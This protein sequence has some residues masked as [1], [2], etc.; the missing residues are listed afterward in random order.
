M[1][2]PEGPTNKM[3]SRVEFIE[4]LR[5]RE[6]S[7]LQSPFG[8]LAIPLDEFQFQQLEQETEVVDI[9][10]RTLFRHF[11]AFG[12]DGRQP[13]RFEMVLEKYGTLGVGLHEATPVSTVATDEGA[14]GESKAP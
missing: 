13:Q 8:R 6:S 2:V 14:G 3:F 11:L 5:S 1:P 12:E 9:V 7:R 4:R 10:G